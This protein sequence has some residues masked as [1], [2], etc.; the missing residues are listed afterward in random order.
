VLAYVALACTFSWA[1]LIP[2]AV[3]GRIVEPGHGW[4]THIPA[5]IGPAVAAVVVTAGTA[6][7]AGLARLG[8]SVLLVRVPARWWVV[9]LS[10]LVVGGVT[11]A[12]AALAGRALPPLRDFGVYPGVPAGW[13]V[14]GVLLAAVIVNG[15]G[16]ETGWRG[17]ALP[18]LEE[19][20]SP[21]TATV[22]LTAGWGIWHVPMFFVL[23]S[24]RS[25]AAP[26]VIGWWLGLLCGA[27]VLT[28]LHDR[29]G[30]STALP[31]V[32]HGTFNLVSATAAAAGLL[33]ATTTTFVMI[34]AV[35]L[36]VLEIRARRRGRP[37]VLSGRRPP[38]W[39]TVSSTAH[40]RTY[41]RNVWISWLQKEGSARAQTDDARRHS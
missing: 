3:A 36:V 17:F 10:P 23:S 16:E 2:Q 18:A 8:H 9:A 39:M 29:S 37:S 14:L 30:G 13:G 24:F 5:L 6:G 4:P 1:W 26:T 27:V 33:A 22:L 21:L 34:G 28:W 7:R 35:L 31:A 15:L 41:A 40:R 11:L 38:Q 12:A 25:F 20:F 32:W 19:R